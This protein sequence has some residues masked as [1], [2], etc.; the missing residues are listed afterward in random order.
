MDPTTPA[1]EAPA[2][3][4][5]TTAPSKRL[6]P[7]EWEQIVVLWE[8]GAVTLRELSDRF[9]IA[10]PSLHEGLKKRGAV[11]GSRA[12]EFAR[13]T[14]DMLKTEA[15]RKA[16]EIRAFKQK[17]GTI[18]D[19]IMNSAVVELQALRAKPRAERTREENARI[20]TAIKYTA[21]VYGNVRDQKY[22][23]YGLYNEADQGDELPEIA[24]TEYTPDEIIAIRDR[25]EIPL[26]DEGDPIIEGAIET[27]EG[28]EEPEAK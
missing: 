9:G 17:F 8:A 18:G 7:Q 20:F 4:A 10:S 28:L 27:L 23:L 21:E 2:E 15:A 22:H 16:E 5:P 19:Y 25:T 14:E 13:Q 11:K 24:V 26:L 1:P 3:T 12:K 6:N